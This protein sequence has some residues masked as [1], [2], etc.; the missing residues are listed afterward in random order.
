M[1]SALARTLARAGHRV[2]V[3]DVQRESAESLA[4][5]GIEA[6]SGLD[7]ALAAGEFVLFS[8]PTYDNVFDL[9]SVA[10]G[11]IDWAGKTVLNLVTG[12][13]AEARR[14]RDVFEG[15]GAG[16]LDGAIFAYPS[17]IGSPETVILVSG[18]YEL[19]D[20]VAE[21]VRALG[22]ESDH[23]GAEIGSANV[24][25]VAMAGAF[26]SVA[27]GGLVEAAAYI[28]AEGVDL[29]AAARAAR[30]EAA[31]IALDIDGALEQIRAGRFEAIDATLAVF[32]EAVEVWQ[33]AMTA[34]GQ[35]AAL[36]TALLEN[37]QTAEG[38]GHANSSFFAQVQSLNA[39]FVKASAA[40]DNS[41]GPS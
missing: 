11:Q 28:Q 34:A 1:G 29:R 39:P 22:G 5:D 30:R 24:V 10:D 32:L 16:Y 15:R 12:T 8:I 21:F 18:P 33:A 14:C 31:Q 7:A 3:Y 23:A 9:L 27:L 35:R 20:R 2:A 36:T 17:G 37:L 13:P 41:A 40:P 4:G 25:D 38:A 26:F 6:A 19:W